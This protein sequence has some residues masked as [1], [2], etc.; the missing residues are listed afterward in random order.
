[1]TTRRGIEY[2]QPAVTMFGIVANDAAKW[3][4]MQIPRDKEPDFLEYPKREPKPP[5]TFELPPDFR[6]R[7]PKKVKSIHKISKSEN[8]NA[9]IAD[10]STAGIAGQDS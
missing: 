8:S 2:M 5:T 9:L 6:K 10:N 4:M 3:D 1:M 7:I